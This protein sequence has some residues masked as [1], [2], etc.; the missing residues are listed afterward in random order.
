MFDTLG[1]KIDDFTYSFTHHPAYTYLRYDI[2]YGVRNLVRWFPIIWQD[3]DWDGAY[4]AR[5]IAKKAGQLAHLQ[6]KYA[7]H[8]DADQCAEDLRTVEA[9]FKFVSKEGIC[10]N[11]GVDCD[12]CAGCDHNEKAIDRAL[13]EGSTL[14]GRR[15]RYWWD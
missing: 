1:R 15:L 3:R 12:W 9:T 4:L 14:I 2:P 7:L 10:F 11:E 13:V 5:I 8:T 6:E